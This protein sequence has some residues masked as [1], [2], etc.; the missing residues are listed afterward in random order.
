MNLKFGK[1]GYIGGLGGTIRKK[2]I[3]LIIISKIK[4]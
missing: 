4:K 2:E 3:A 1:E